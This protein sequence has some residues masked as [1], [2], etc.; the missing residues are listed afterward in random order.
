MT[1]TKKRGLGASVVKK[2]P[3]NTAKKAKSATSDLENG[4]GVN[5]WLS[6][7][8]DQTQDSLNQSELN[9]DIEI[10]AVPISLIMIDPTN[11]RDLSV[12]PDELDKHLE[13]IKLP[14][15]AFLENDDWIEPYEAK[16]QSVFGD[17]EK[18]KDIMGLAAFAAAIKSPR[19][20]MSPICVWREDSTF[21]IFA[22]ERR[23]LSHYF[24]GAAHV[25]VRIWYE[26]PSQL[27]MKV[28]QWQENHER[29]DLKPYE[30]LVN[31]RQIL[32]EWKTFNP[33]K[34]ITVRSFAQLISMGRTQAAQ[35]LKV[36]QCNYSSL[37]Q[38]LETC[39]I[40][41]VESAYELACME[42]DQVDRCIEKIQAGGTV[43]KTI[44]DEKTQF[45]T[46]KAGNVDETTSDNTASDIVP[47]KFNRKADPKPVAFMLKS[48]AEKMGDDALIQA[49]G[50]FNFKKPSHV[51]KAIS[52]VFDHLKDY[53]EGY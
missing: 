4:G 27:D 31:I 29:E 9:N 26:K 45:S 24:L 44:A 8:Q 22:G 53:E 48:V 46:N 6:G 11:P 28:L 2:Q 14:P 10:R 21:Y 30:K 33:N 1:K 49:L 41:G 39:L 23:Y 47:I 37:N 20:I 25:I 32:H 38:A 51:N 17:T 36:S 50:K 13:T 7:I 40:G 5:K 52:M 19:N 18:T 35:W 42:S 3:K 16:I 34:K 12:T 43:S 15:E